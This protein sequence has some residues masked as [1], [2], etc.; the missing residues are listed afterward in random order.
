MAHAKRVLAAV[1]LLRSLTFHLLGSA[2]QT[3]SATLPILITGFNVPRC[4]L[5]AVIPQDDSRQTAHVQHGEEFLKEGGAEA[6]GGGGMGDLF[7]MLSGQGRRQQRGPTKSKD[8]K[9]EL[10]V[11]LKDFYLGTTKCA[12]AS[13]A[14]CC[15]R[16]TR[17]PKLPSY[18]GHLRVFNE[19]SQI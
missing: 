3:R 12:R 14:C 1:A 4:L 9:Q 13:F 8:T 16:S 5:R 6:G 10:P 19:R 15:V 18:R 11:S 17:Y 7:D 2:K